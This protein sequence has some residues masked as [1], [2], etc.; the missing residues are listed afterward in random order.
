MGSSATDPKAYHS[1]DNRNEETLDWSLWKKACDFFTAIADGSQEMQAVRMALSMT[2]EDGGLSSGERWAIIIK[3]WLYYSA[4]KEITDR[5]LE[6]QYVANEYG[7]RILTECPVI[8]G[9]DL[10]NPPEPSE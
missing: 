1:A 6:L 7:G 9:I 3:A 5:S 4:D 8:G 10:G 2:D